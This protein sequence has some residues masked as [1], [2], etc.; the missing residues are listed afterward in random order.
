V[1]ESAGS[2]GD[3]EVFDVVNNPPSVQLL[4][5]P[6]VV[7]GVAKMGVT[8]S[9]ADPNLTGLLNVV[10]VSEKFYYARIPLK[11]TGVVTQ[12]GIRL[13]VEPVTVAISRDKALAASNKSSSKSR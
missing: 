4:L 2:R 12:G 11:L 1:V 9:S 7:S 13:D 3:L 5:A 10:V 6:D 8:F